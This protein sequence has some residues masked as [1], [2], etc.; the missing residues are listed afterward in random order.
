LPVAIE[1][2]VR[3]GGIAESRL[4][5]AK[6]VAEALFLSIGTGIAAAVIN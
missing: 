2:D 1:H 4:G 5:A 6:D 3:A